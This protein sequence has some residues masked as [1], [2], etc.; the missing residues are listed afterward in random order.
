[1]NSRAILLIAGF[2]ALTSVGLAIP[3][4]CSNA[5]M[6]V[7]DAGGYSC[8][9]GDM[10][11]SNFSYSWV[12]SADA[13]YPGIGFAG[14]SASVPDTTVNVTVDA[15]NMQITFGGNWQV[16]RY[17][18]AD[19]TIQYTAEICQLAT[20]GFSSPDVVDQF[21]NQFSGGIGGNHIS[22]NLGSGNTAMYTPSN[23][24][25]Y[26]AAQTSFSTNT[27]FN[28]PGG[29]PGPITILD[30]AHL[31]SNNLVN[32]VG[33]GPLGNQTA[34]LSFIADSF[35]PAQPPGVPEPMSFVLLGG[36]LLTLAGY[37]KFR[38]DSK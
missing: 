12:A 15:A 27:L 35:S 26:P 33:G 2:L 21:R 9:V 22:G 17:M 25:T 10:L 8:T 7:Y 38:H 6:N 4:S 24:L 31:D 14:T 30:T 5:T 3:V 11:F 19:L 13:N 1:M 23:K 29:T 34:H 36:G 32:P 37:K 18:Q 28:F 20:C 16:T